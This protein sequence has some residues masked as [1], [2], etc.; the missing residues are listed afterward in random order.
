MNPEKFDKYCKDK[1]EELNE[2]PIQGWNKENAWQRIGSGADN[3][4]TGWVKYAAASLFIYVVRTYKSAASMSTSTKIISSVLAGIII[5][6]AIYLSYTV[7]NNNNNQNNTISKN[8]LELQKKT[9]NHNSSKPD[10]IIP[11]ENKDNL[12]TV[13]ESPENIK[14]R[15]I[16]TESEYKY[17]ISK[18][19]QTFP[20]KT[21]KTVQDK[22]IPEEKKIIKKEA[23]KDITVET[24]PGTQKPVRKEKKKYDV[25]E[26][27]GRFI[28][29]NDI[30]HYKILVFK[31][32]LFKKNDHELSSDAIDELNQVINT[33]QLF[34][35]LD[36][37]IIGHA[38]KHEKK[39]LHQSYS[40]YR[41]NT[42]KQYLLSQGINKQRISTSGKGITVPESREKDKKSHILNRRV[43]VVVINNN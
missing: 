1:V 35:D 24:D 39:Y 36:V 42:V 12:I 6:S 30:K 32:L 15:G 4:K 38:D 10:N 34:P 2:V 41:A 19:E 33:L 7:K 28:K 22:G 17:N 11:G 16:T 13:N 43:E 27:Y 9:N 14:K 20:E 3:I 18:N 40:D 23:G 25:M 5:C 37:Q 29:D 8:T 21:D 26:D 31:V